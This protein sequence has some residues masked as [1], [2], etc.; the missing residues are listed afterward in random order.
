MSI[1]IVRL[2]LDRVLAPKVGRVPV[3]PAK[4]VPRYRQIL[5]LAI[6]IGLHIPNLRQPAPEL[7]GMLGHRWIIWVD[8][9]SRICRG[10][11]GRTGRTTR[12]PRTA[13]PV[14]YT[15]LTLP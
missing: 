11:T 8:V 12:R 5:C 13:I 2:V 4:V 1:R 7:I 3:A 15:H 9:R 10:R 6:V 14:S